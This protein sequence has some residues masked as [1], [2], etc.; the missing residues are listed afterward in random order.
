MKRFFPSTLSR[1]LATTYAISFLQLFGVLLGIVYLFETVE[2]LRRAAKF[3]DVPFTLVLQ[4]GLLKLPEVGQIILPFAVLFSALYTFWFLVRRHE[5]VILRAAGLSVWQFL[6]PIV[7]VA[8]LV[9]FF[10]MMVINPIGAMLITRYQEMEARYL[11]A[12]GATDRLD[13]EVVRTHVEALH[14]MAHLPHALCEER[15]SVAASLKR[16]V[17]KKLKQADAA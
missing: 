5:L 3:D 8:M 17:D 10:H 16:M 13:P 11:Q 9:G 14:Q 2:L 7:G 1:Y 15:Q 6:A 12:Q 4:M